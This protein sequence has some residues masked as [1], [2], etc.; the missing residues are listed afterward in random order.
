[1]KRLKSILSVLLIFFSGLIVG[2]IIAA[3][4]TVHDVVSKTFRDGPQSVRRVLLQRAKHDLKL[5]E[6]QAHQF[7]QIFNETGAELREVIKPVQP[8]VQ[9]TLQRAE[10]RLRAVLKPH[11]AAPFDS[12][13]KAA[14]ARW[15]AA[16]QS[17][18]ALEAN[19]ITAPPPLQ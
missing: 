3:G 4:A 8:E 1:M 10:L 13:M 15:S 16:M 7:W 9:S 6:D 12:F 17:P 2:G 18:A 11:Q 14:R 5:D 19:A